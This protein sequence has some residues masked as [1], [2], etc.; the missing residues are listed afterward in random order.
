MTAS[1]LRYNPTMGHNNIKKQFIDNQVRVFREK[2]PDGAGLINKHQIVLGMIHQFSKPSDRILDVGCSD[3]K[4]LKELSGLGYRKLYGVDIQEWAKTSLTGTRI[5][6]RDCD[7]EN[8]PL[9]FTGK[10]DL[11]IIS[12]VLEHMFSPQSVLYD[13]KK[14]LSPK[15]KIIF[16]VPNAGWF[17][18]G[19][20]LTFFPSKLFVST[21]FGPWGHT[22]QFTFF[23]LRKIA[24]KLEYKIVELKGG[25]LDNY[26]FKQGI[27]KYLFDLF[28]WITLPLATRLPIIFSAHIFGVLENT[29][30]VPSQRDRF[31]VGI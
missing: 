1:Q 24:S 14:H 8:E 4:I 29:S 21:A 11:I 19:V 31:D 28:V 25:K 26:A 27:K 10:F 30:R 13:L 15:G 23:E 2:E 22:H 5:T 3:G 7:I 20:L 6:Y 17:L 12:D 9:P 16:S 18:N